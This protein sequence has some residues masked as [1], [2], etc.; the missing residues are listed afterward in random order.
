M[1]VD[2]RQLA[3]RLHEP[4]AC[5][6]R[7]GLEVRGR[8]VAEHAPILDALGLV[9]LLRADLVGHPGLLVTEHCSALASRVP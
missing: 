5:R 3:D 2:A 6:E 8:T 7:P 9:E 4:G 1:V